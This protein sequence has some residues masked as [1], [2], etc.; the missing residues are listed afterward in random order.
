MKAETPAPAPNTEEAG[1]ELAYNKR[2]R[3]KNGTKWADIA[4][5]NTAR[6]SIVSFSTLKKQSVD[7]SS[8]W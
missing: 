3:I 4:D 8:V 6:E 2:N 7:Y 5:K 1:A